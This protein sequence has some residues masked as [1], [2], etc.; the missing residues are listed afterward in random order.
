MGKKLYK[1]N[2]LWLK[3]EKI[4][5][6]FVQTELFTLQIHASIF[7]INYA[8]KWTLQPEQLFNLHPH[9]TI[10]FN[11]IIIAFVCKQLSNTI[12]TSEWFKLWRWRRN[13]S[14]NIVNHIQPDHLHSL[15]GEPPSKT[16]FDPVK[17]GLR[18]E[19]SSLR[20]SSTSI[21]IFPATFH[22]LANRRRGTRQRRSERI[23]TQSSWL[24]GEEATFHSLQYHILWIA[25]LTL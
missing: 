1:R 24:K 8:T 4:T 7:K 6:F 16:F 19:N 9:S 22:S 10:S 12:I 15:S 23:E 17:T 11:S 21:A 13:D 5:S 14:A 20:S 3:M 25:H 18:I 2:L